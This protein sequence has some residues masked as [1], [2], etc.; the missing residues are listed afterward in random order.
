M[1]SAHLPWDVFPHCGGMLRG[2]SL[3]LYSVC[4]DGEKKGFRGSPEKWLNLQGKILFWRSRKSPP[5]RS[6]SKWTPW[7]IWGNF[8]VFGETKQKSTSPFSTVASVACNHA[9]SKA[10]CKWLLVSWGQ[11]PLQRSLALG[12]EL[13]PSKCRVGRFS[14][15]VFL[16]ALDKVLDPTQ[17]IL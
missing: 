11:C 7:A 2:L 14:C 10:C 16:T 8:H 15:F 4:W 5:F 3:V 17:D 13:F 12:R 9:S 1:A 6:A